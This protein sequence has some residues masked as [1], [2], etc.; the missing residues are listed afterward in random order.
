MIKFM[1]LYTIFKDT[2]QFYLKYIYIYMTSMLIPVYSKKL[3]G[4]NQKTAPGL[5]RNLN[6]NVN[7]YKGSYNRQNN[8]LLIKFN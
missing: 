7:N 2:H 1:I 3:F 6:L 8:R 5:S 4:V